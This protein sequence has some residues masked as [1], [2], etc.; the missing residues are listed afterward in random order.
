MVSKTV[1]YIERRQ[2]EMCSLLRKLEVR[3]RLVEFLRGEGIDVDSGSRFTCGI[4]SIG[5]KVVA[6]KLNGVRHPIATD[7]TV[8]DWYARFV[9]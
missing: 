9:N 8:A 5:G 3:N 2:K 1:E 4:V 7:I 6:I